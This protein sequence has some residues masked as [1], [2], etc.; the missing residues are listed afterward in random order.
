MFSVP[1]RFNQLARPAPP[2]RPSGYPGAGKTTRTGRS[3]KAT[4]EGE[5]LPTR[6][7]LNTRQGRDPSFPAPQPQPHGQ[8]VAGAFTSS[9][10]EFRLPGV[11]GRAFIRWPLVFVRRIQALAVA[12]TIVAIADSP[13]QPELKRGERNRGDEDKCNPEQHQ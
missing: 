11:L 7:A 13:E 9:R 4:I 1:R 2:A 5:T 10:R 3:H 12:T 8:E 6:T